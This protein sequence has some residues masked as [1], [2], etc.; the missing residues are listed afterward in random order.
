MYHCGRTRRKGSDTTFL[1]LNHLG[2][3]NADRCDLASSPCDGRRIEAILTGTRTLG[4]TGERITDSGA[5]VSLHA[6]GN[7]QQLGNLVSTGS[8]Q[9]AAQ[10]LLSSLV[11]VEHFA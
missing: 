8:F 6:L 4:S 11:L 1:S 3:R 10:A 9:T 7:G 2:Q 5:N